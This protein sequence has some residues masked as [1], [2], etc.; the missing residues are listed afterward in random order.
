LTFDG[1]GV[2]LRGMNTTNE[3]CEFKPGDR[4]VLRSGG[5]GMTVLDV[6]AFTGHVWCR[7]PVGQGAFDEASF[8]PDTITADPRLHLG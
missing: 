7:W 3:N 1:A 6:G 2:Y 4:V 8:H 5:P